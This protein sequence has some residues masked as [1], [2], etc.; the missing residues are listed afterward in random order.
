MEGRGDPEKGREKETP[1]K[2]GALHQRKVLQMGGTLKEPWDG[3]TSWVTSLLRKGAQRSRVPGEQALGKRSAL[4]VGLRPRTEALEE[5][6]LAGKDPKFS[7]EKQ[8]L[9]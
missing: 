9:E 5:E 8:L 3:V 2:E 6:G 4:D 1:S 7:S